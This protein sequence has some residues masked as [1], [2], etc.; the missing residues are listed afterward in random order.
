MHVDAGHGKCYPCCWMLLISPGSVRTRNTTTTN[1]ASRSTQRRRIDCLAAAIVP[2]RFIS[3]LHIILKP[4]L[5]LFNARSN[6]P[7][8]MPVTRRLRLFCCRLPRPKLDGIKIRSLAVFGLGPACSSVHCDYMLHFDL[9]AAKRAGCMRRESI[10]FCGFL[11]DHKGPRTG[12]GEEGKQNQSV[13]F[14]FF[15]V[16]LCVSLSW[17]LSTCLHPVDGEE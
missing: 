9:S 17:M 16:V 14:I 15:L 7:T 6:Q 8:P 4:N 3:F 11:H 13:A 1:H 5:P 2:S 12:G 10:G